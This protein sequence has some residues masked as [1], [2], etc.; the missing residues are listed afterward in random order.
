MVGP[1]D[2]TPRV[3]ISYARDPASDAIRKR[4]EDALR[5]AGFE[6]WLVPPAQQV[7]AERDEYLRGARA[8]VAIVSPLALESEWMRHEAALLARRA[9]DD[10]EFRLVAMTNGEVPREALAELAE[11]A[12][13]DGLD[14]DAQIAQVLARL[15]GLRSAA[16][17]GGGGGQM[18]RAG[19]HEGGVHALALVTLDGRP[20]V[21]T[22]DGVG[23]LRVIEIATDTLRLELRNMHSGFVSAIAVGVLAGVPVAVSGG[24]DGFVRVLDLVDARV[25]GAQQ[26]QPGGIGGLA[27]LDV[28]P[29]PLAVAGGDDG[30]VQA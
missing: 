26:L 18:L 1:D 12:V 2:S 10:P 28:S 15:A 4:L 8:A 9:S 7:Q 24:Y 29:G 13:D 23:T 30:A 3:F 6:H 27:L 14:V 17:A 11:F 16:P 20:C 22:G 19:A 21:V 5:E 25:V